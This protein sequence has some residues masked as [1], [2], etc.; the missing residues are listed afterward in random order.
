[1]WGLCHTNAQSRK[2]G[3]LQPLRAVLYASTT[4][5]AICILSSWHQWWIVTHFI[6]LITCQL[7]LYN[8]GQDVVADLQ[9]VHPLEE[10]LG[11]HASGVLALRM[12]YSS[13]CNSQSSYSRFLHDMDPRLRCAVEP[14]DVL[15]FWR[16]SGGI[17][18]GTPWMAV[19]AVDEVCMSTTDNQDAL[20]FLRVA[21]SFA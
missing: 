15:Y 17:E 19:F 8:A 7:W 4:M 13:V 18:E 5:I 16:Q 12:L 6:N 9:E 2:L 3:D 11:W 1:M 10:A 14:L 20:C 21:C